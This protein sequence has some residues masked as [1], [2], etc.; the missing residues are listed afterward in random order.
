ML[1]EESNC[2]IK[3]F[4]VSYQL[5]SE[6]LQK[7]AQQYFSRKAN[8]YQQRS[9]SG[10]WAIVRSLESRA[11]LNNLRLQ[12][13]DC[14]LEIGCGS[15][16]YSKLIH[17]RVARLKAIDINSEMVMAARSQGVPALQ[18]DIFSQPENIL[19]DQILIAGVL[20]F[21]S[22]PGP[23][24]Q[25]ARRLLR[26]GGRLV[27]LRPQTGLI[28][29]VYFLVH[30]LSGCPVRSP[31]EIRALFTGRQDRWTHFP[32]GPLAR[33]SLWIKDPE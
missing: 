18:E 19:Y 15:G 24:L 9:A 23:I 3:F 28:G 5:T 32:A 20:E 4:P 14:C 10:L 27:V 33:G 17:S 25:R 16:F 7:K 30:F 11:I 29:Q 31:S 12:P 1:P 2:V 6:E 13:T 26:P 21:C 22:F 8:E